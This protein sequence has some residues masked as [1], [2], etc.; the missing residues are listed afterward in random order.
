[1]K[2]AVFINLVTVILSSFCATLTENA[3]AAYTLLVPLPGSGASPDLAT[4]I[5]AAVQTCIILAALL[6]VVMIVVA[7][8]MYITAGGNPGRIE[9]AKKY[10]WDAII[11][12]LIAVGYY[13]ILLALHPNFLAGTL[14]IETEGHVWANR[15]H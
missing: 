9:T 11:G 1:M 6:A 12:L 10:I 7:G 3:Q 8:F 14:I 13:L 15:R 4:Y 5:A 2:R